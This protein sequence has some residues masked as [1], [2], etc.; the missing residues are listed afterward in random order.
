VNATSVLED[1]IDFARLWGELSDRFRLGTESLHGRSHWERVERWGVRL[2]ETTPGADL[3]VVRLFAVF[4]DCE[5][6]NESWDPDHGRR[7]ARYVRKTHGR[8][9]TLSAAQLE[10]LADAC[11]GHV[12]G[13]T[14]N[15]PTIGCCWDADR[16]DLPRVCINPDPEYMSTPHGR[17]LATPFHRR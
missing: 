17:Q 9:F 4:H 2:V 5:R 13:L 12:D 8:W 10:L 16:L 7:A 1:G 6:H 14:S 11:A 15:D 3:L